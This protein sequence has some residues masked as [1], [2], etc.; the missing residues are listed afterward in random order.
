MYHYGQGVAQDYRKAAEWYQKAAFNGH[1]LAQVRL[2]DLCYYERGIKQDCAKAQKLYRKAATQGNADAL[3]VLAEICFGDR[4]YA[5]A[6]RYFHES[7]EKGNAEAQYRLGVMYF[8]GM[9]GTPDQ[10]GIPGD[11][12][13]AMKWFLEAA[14]DGDADAQKML[15]DIYSGRESSDTGPDYELAA[16]WY[17][18]AAGNGNA[19]AGECLRT[20]QREGKILL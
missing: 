3:C 7:A 19:D 5:W 6:A 9:R 10:R 14:G 11:R 13:K 8:R 18:E 17:R 20:L 1:V 16:K 4:K 12:R 2:A 15:G